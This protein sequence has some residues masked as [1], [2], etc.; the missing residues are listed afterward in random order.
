MLKTNAKRV[1]ADSYWRVF[2][3]CFIV[4]LLG[5]SSSSS[6]SS[7]TITAL[8]SSTSAISQSAAMGSSYGSVGTVEIAFLAG[9]L[10]IV[11]I[12][13]LIGLLFAIFLSAPLSVSLNRYMMENRAGFPPYS[14]LLT[15]F[16]DKKQYWNV[17]KVMFLYNLEIFLWTLLCFIPGIY[18][19]YQ[20]IYVPYLLAENPYLS[21]S[22]AKELSRAMTNNEKMEI[23]VLGL[24]FIGWSLLG[25]MACGIGA[26]FVVPYVTATY[27]ELYAAARAKAFALG[28]TDQNELGGFTRYARPQPQ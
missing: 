6:G 12:A 4:G 27:A 2:L 11:L 24:S 10:M 22:R 28:V 13:C 9:I 25:A 1:L 21:Y 16:Q 7:A 14:S 8:N 20:Y 19:S 5:G 3:V 17:V 26:L 18:K 15:V 23:F